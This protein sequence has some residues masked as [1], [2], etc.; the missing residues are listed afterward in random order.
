MATDT[1]SSPLTIFSADALPSKCTT[2]CPFQWAPGG[3]VLAVKTALH[4]SVLA[5]AMNEPP[6]PGQMLQEQR[7]TGAAS[8]ARACFILAAAFK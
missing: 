6:Q 4:R 2:Q 3:G 5:G 7:S 1:D 8:S